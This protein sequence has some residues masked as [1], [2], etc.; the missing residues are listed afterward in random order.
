M[1]EPSGGAVGGGAWWYADSSGNPLTDVDGRAFDAG[2]IVDDW[3]VCRTGIGGSIAGGN[4]PQQ[5]LG[6]RIAAAAATA[7]GSVSLQALALLLASGG[8]IAGGNSPQQALG[9]RIA[10]AAATAGGSVPHQALALLLASGGSIAGGNINLL[11]VGNR[12][13]TAAAVTGG[14]ILYQALAE[15]LVSGG[16]I[17]GGTANL[18]TMALQGSTGGAVVGGTF[19]LPPSPTDLLRVCYTVKVSR[20]QFLADNYKTTVRR[21]Y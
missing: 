11:A 10:A 16:S 2:T 9:N 7:G 4:S 3:Q 17:A 12:P 8:S 20:Q 21:R 15:Q 19:G 14:N 13:A 5:A 6:N 1:P 18:L